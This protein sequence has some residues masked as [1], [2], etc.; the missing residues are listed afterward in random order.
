MVGRSNTDLVSRSRMEPLHAACMIPECGLGAN[1]KLTLLPASA[2]RQKLFVSLSSPW[3]IS[4]VTLHPH[5]LGQAGSVKVQLVA[6][7]FEKTFG[8]DTA[9]DYLLRVVQHAVT[10]NVKALEVR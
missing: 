7:V 4:V 10:V 9:T 8:H 6:V 3:Q 5:L 2:V 1:E